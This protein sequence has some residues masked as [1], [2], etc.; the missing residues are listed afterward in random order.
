MGAGLSSSAALDL[1][2]ARAFSL[3]GGFQWDPI[4]M[5]VI[6]KQSENQWIGLNN[7]IMDQLISATGEK[8]KAILIDCRS[9]IFNLMRYRPIRLSLS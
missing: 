5:S 7:G 2:T 9:L 3:I 6:S 4:Q 8:G 1:V